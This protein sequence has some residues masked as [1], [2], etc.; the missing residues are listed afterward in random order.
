MNK[1]KKPGGAPAAMAPGYSRV[2]PLNLDHAYVSTADGKTLHVQVG[3]TAFY[4][5]VATLVG[6]PAQAVTAAHCASLAE[7][8]VNPAGNRLTPDDRR[9]AWLNAHRLLAVDEDG[10]TLVGLDALLPA[11]SE[12]SESAVDSTN[13]PA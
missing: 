13:A 10:K 11:S 9:E 1:N 6:S 7:S 8:H 4:T 2:I 12:A 5:A 3:S